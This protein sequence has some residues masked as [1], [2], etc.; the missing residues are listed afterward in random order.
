MW[1]FA[2][3]LT[4]LFTTFTHQALG[5]GEQQWRWWSG[6]SGLEQVVRDRQRRGP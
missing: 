2:C 4:N 1:R 6:R 3:R 5:H